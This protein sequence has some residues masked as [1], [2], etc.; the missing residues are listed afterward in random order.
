ML[1]AL[2]LDKH[3]PYDT[4]MTGEVL[5]MYSSTASQQAVLGPCAVTLAVC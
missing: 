5:Y 2:E 3:M 4:A 1:R